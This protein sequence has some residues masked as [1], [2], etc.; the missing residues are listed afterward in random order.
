MRVRYERWD[1][2]LARR[3][4]DR[5]TLLRLFH[6]L[7]L[8]TGGDVEAALRALREMQRLGYLGAAFNLDEFRRELEEGDVVRR[9][10]DGYHLTH[11]GE[12]A[13]RRDALDRVFSSLRR[14]GPGEHRTADAGSGGELLA[15]TRPYEFGDEPARIDSRQTLKNALRRG[16]IEDFTLAEPDFE[17]HETEHHTSCATVL[18]LDISHS[19]VL[20]GEDR[21]TPAKRVAL[22]LAELI[23]TRYPKDSLD[24]VLFGDEAIEVPLSKIVYAEVGP[25]HTNTKAGLRMAQGILRRKKHANKQIFMVTDGKPSAIV[26]SGRIYK[27][28]IGLDP[29]IIQQTLQEAAACRRN[30]IVITTFMVARDAHLVEFVDQ[31]TR[32]NRGRAYYSSLQSLGEFL[33]VDYLQNRRRRVHG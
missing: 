8:R 3:P 13:I 21:F 7:V 24:V 12:R 5:A 17:V 26:E 15:E 14:A 23:T 33:F 31:L 2:D 29:R 28:P 6:Y 22:A 9:E 20:Y 1:D 11:R 32:I 10:A 16:G 18:L 4:R 30:R 27:N 19:M 25:Y